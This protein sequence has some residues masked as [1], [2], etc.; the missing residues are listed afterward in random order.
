MEIVVVFRYPDITDL[1][2][3]EATFAIDSLTDSITS[4][5]VD[6]DSWHIDEALGDVPSASGQCPPVVDGK[7]A[8]AAPD[9]LAALRLCC[10]R[11]AEWVY[12]GSPD[13]DDFEAVKA[14]R[15]AIA[16]AEGRS[17]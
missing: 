13:D 11:L 1:D 3:T 7:V 12:R 9:L 16:K 4:A 8:A 15:Q 17:E 6:C 14:A 10:E 5:G 2:S